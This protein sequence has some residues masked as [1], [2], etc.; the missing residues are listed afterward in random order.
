MHK[1]LIK[2]LL[3]GVVIIAF[4]FQA[5]ALDVDLEVD[6]NITTKYRDCEPYARDIVDLC[7]LAI[8]CEVPEKIKYIY[9]QIDFLKK[10]LKSCEKSNKKKTKDTKV[11]VGAKKKFD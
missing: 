2:I 7:K 3:S 4:S 10:Q 8:Q 11:K 1:K 9:E 5:H 6:I